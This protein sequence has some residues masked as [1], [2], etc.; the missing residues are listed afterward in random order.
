M[1]NLS[2]VFSTEPLRRTIRKKACPR[3]VGIRVIVGEH[4]VRH[5]PE[6][7]FRR[8][9]GSQFLSFLKGKCF[10]FGQGKRR[11]GNGRDQLHEMVQ[12]VHDG[13]TTD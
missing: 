4:I 1:T 11:D 10:S 12:I 2:P 9:I 8:E 13:E 6:F 7:G 5:D 3:K